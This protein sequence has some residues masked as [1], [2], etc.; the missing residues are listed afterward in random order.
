LFEILTRQNK[1]EMQKLFDMHVATHYFRLTKVTP[2]MHQLVTEFYNRYTIHAL[3]MEKRRMVMR[4]TKKAF[5]SRTRDNR[6]FRFHI[7]QLPAF[8]LFL[9]TNYIRTSLYNVIHIPLHQAV[10]VDLPL[11]PGKKLYPYQEPI[12]DYLI[13][14]NQKPKM[15]L[16]QTGKGKTL[17]SLAAASRIGLRVLISIKAAYIPK[18]CSDVI[19][20]FDIKPKDIMTVQGSDQ[21]KGIMDLA[22]NN[23]LTAKVI[24]IATRTHQNFID[25]YEQD[26]YAIRDFGWDFTPDEILSK[27]GIG[28][29]LIDEVHQEF[30]G[31][32]R[33]MM[34]SN[35]Q[36]SINLSA[37]L[38]SNNAFTQEMYDTIFPKDDRYAG[39]EY[40]RYIKAFPYSYSIRDMEKVRTSEFG[41]TMYSHNAFEKSIIRQHKLLQ[42]YLKM[43]DYIVTLGFLERY[44]RGD[45]VAVFASS[46]AMCD[47]LKAFFQRSYPRLKVNR[48]VEED[49]YE[50]CITG[51]IIV[52]TVLSGGTAIDIPGLTTV[53]QTNSIL[54]YQSN[55]QTMGRLRKLSY[56]DV[57]F[58][59]IYCTDIPKQVDYHDSR[60]ALIKDLVVL[61]KPM[62]Y[63]SPL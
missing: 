24:I 4:P 18:W 43:V 1:M 63:H 13:V 55:V 25:Q 28:T 3:I 23:L 34:Y 52:T 56:K 35:V 44:E 40:D 60:I 20:N 49:P 22:E 29:L 5:A 9:A 57:R 30:H 41:S 61:I 15:A 32:Y 7:N 36:H 62:S 47:E 33:G 45:K 58:Y 59:W 31:H 37:T 27:L 6:I 50:N 42:A 11:R 39:L 12:V 51:D 21:L 53:V 38:I 26:R 46:V 2:R 10:K 16:V 14:D 54:S 19:E 48:Y 17:M 8:N